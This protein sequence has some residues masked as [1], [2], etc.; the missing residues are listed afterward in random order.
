[1]RKEMPDDSIALTKLDSIIETLRQSLPKEFTLGT[2][3][4]GTSQGTQHHY[5]DLHF[6]ADETVPGLYYAQLDARTLSNG[7]GN[8]APMQVNDDSKV[9]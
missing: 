3:G 8:H 9:E 2:V 5:P 6:K 7:N 1:M 4:N